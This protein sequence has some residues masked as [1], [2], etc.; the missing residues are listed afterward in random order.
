[1]ESELESLS[2]E[3]WHQI[4]LANMGGSQVEGQI[5]CLACLGF[6]LLSLFHFL[7]QTGFI[8]DSLFIL[9]SFFK[10]SDK[11]RKQGKTMRHKK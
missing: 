11:L 10:S 5:Q 3:F 7:V 6:H 9:S 2:T 1:M 4:I 8:A